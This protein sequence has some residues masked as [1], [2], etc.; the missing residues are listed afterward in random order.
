MHN[1]LVPDTTGTSRKA[2]LAINNHLGNVCPLPHRS[3]VEEARILSSS[4]EQN[5]TPLT[6]RPCFLFS[7]MPCFIQKIPCT[8]STSELEFCSYHPLILLGAASAPEQS[9]AGSRDEAVW[10]KTQCSPQ[11]RVSVPTQTYVGSILRLQR[12]FCHS[13]F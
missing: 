6:Q 10:E 13:S 8:F 3:M 7:T 4:P 5:S 11:T 12:S 9:R 2:L 1:H